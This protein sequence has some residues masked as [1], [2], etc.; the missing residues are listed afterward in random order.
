MAAQYGSSS[1]PRRRSIYASTPPRPP[2]GRRQA[3]L[4]PHFSLTPHDTPFFPCI[5]DVFFFILTTALLGESLPSRTEEE[6]LSGTKSLEKLLDWFTAQLITIGAEERND[7]ED[8]EEPENS[9]F[10]MLGR[11]LLHTKASRSSCAP[12]LYAMHRDLWEL[13][14]ESTFLEDGSGGGVLFV[15][16]NFTHF[17]AFDDFQLLVGTGLRHLV[18]KELTVTAYH[19]LHPSPSKRAPVPALHLFLDSTELFVE[20]S[21]DLTSLGF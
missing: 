4:T 16:P 12:S 11:A 15:T 5:T 7:D 19:P 13:V 17:E 10:V 18:S 1:S 9:K 2:K 20:G 21:G 6:Q 14:T 3:S 8:E